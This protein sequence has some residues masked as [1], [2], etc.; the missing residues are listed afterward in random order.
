MTAEQL[1][2]A[3]AERST[4]LVVDFYATWCAAPRQLPNSATCAAFTAAPFLPRD[5]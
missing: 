5:G 2:V 3:I 4:V 1:E